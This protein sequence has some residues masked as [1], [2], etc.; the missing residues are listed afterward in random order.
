MSVIQTLDWALQG[1]LAR[2]S[3]RVSLSGPKV[4]DRP[5][6]KKA[7]LLCPRM[8]AVDPSIPLANGQDLF[9][10]PVVPLEEKE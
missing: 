8:W 7:T 4:R 9:R 2:Y 3:H 10:A 6:N 5:S 1:D